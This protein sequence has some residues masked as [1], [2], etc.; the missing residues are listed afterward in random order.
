MKKAIEII[1]GVVM[2]VGFTV[3]AG[4]AGASD[5]NTISLGTAILNSMIG[6]IIIAGGFMLG[7][8]GGVL[9]E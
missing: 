7:R 1:S 4:T 3:I 6:L 5:L 9:N 2:T 8:I